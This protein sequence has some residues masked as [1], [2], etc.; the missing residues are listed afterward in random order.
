MP[1]PQKLNPGIT[2]VSPTCPS[3]PNGPPFP[4]NQ[5][6]TVGIDFDGRPSKA[7]TATFGCFL[8]S[9]NTLPNRGAFQFRD[10]CKNRKHHLARRR[11]CVDS[12]SQANE[13]KRQRLELF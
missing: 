11:R 10:R 4:T 7:D 5:P 12:F 13:V 2:R 8:S 3:L 9:Y 6:P 1:G